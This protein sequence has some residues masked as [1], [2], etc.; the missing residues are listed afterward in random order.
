MAID[1]RSIIL[2]E[3]IVKPSFVGMIGQNVEE[4]QTDKES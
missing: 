3:R 1:N 2:C 4:D